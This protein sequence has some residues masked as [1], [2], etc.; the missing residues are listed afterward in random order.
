MGGWL[1]LGFRAI[2]LQLDGVQGCIRSGED[3]NG[4]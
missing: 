1:L 2:D 4:G 3:G